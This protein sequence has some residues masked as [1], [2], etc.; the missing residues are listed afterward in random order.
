MLMCWVKLHFQ[1]LGVC[2]NAYTPFPSYIYACILYLHTLWIAS[3]IFNLKL[4]FIVFFSLAFLTSLFFFLLVLFS[5]HQAYRYACYFEL[6]RLR[7]LHNRNLKHN[8]QTRKVFSRRSFI[9]SSLRIIILVVLSCHF[10][11]II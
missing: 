4:V 3:S 8:E 9:E 6:Q 1:S 5:L 10:T 11:S 7:L 2:R